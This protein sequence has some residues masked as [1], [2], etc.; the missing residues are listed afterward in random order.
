M[1]NEV[2]KTTD[3]SNNPLVSVI[4]PVYNVGKY[5]R[6]C[7]DSVLAQTYTEYEVL[8]IDDGS[9]DSSADIC[10]EYCKKDSRFK[11]YQKQNGGASSARNLGLFHSKGKYVYFL[12]SDD[13]I[14]TNAIGKMVVCAS[15]NCADLVFI[16]AQTKSD[17]GVPS[18]GHYGYHRQYTADSP[19]CIMEEMLNNKEFHVGTPFFFIQKEVFETNNLRFKEGIISEDM[20]MAYQLFS[21]AKRGAHIH[22]YLYIRRYRPS[23]VTTSK[24]TEK[25]YVS[26]ATV[27]REVAKFRKTLPEE[28]QSPKHLIRCAYNVLSIYRQMTP[29]VRKKYKSDY[30][31]IVKDI[32]DNNAYGDK[33]LELDCKSHLLWGAYKLKKKLL[34]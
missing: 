18:S 4:I 31:E 32:L 21:L 16:E 9:T 26:M 23:S 29:E 30:N 13:E 3:I 8:L 34:K 10:R 27:Y 25:N 33:A 24:K 7:L 28:K 14:T 2:I 20:I 17:D 1:D 11:L 22:E 5:L 12:D 15:E 6:Q 19:Y